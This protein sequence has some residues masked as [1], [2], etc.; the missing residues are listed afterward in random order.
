MST[1]RIDFISAYCDRWCERCAYTSRCSAFAV[2]AAI[3]MCGDVREGLELAVGAPRSVEPELA[4][5]AAAEWSAELANADMSAEEFAEFER[6]EKERRAR[7]DQTPIMKIAHAV[8]VLAYRWCTARYDTVL[9]G[10]DVVLKEALE[11]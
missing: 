1:D 5:A 4:E 7:I 2:S 10:A 3:A 6:R 11:I 9:A 8:T